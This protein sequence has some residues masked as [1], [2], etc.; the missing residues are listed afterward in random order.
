MELMKRPEDLDRVRKS[1]P[2][3]WGKKNEHAKDL[4]KFMQNGEENKFKVVFIGDNGQGDLVAAV[5]LL[6]NSEYADCIDFAYI[7]LVVDNPYISLQCLSEKYKMK[8]PL[9]AKDLY[10]FESYVELAFIMFYQELDSMPME[11]LKNIVE[12]YKKEIE[13]RRDQLNLTIKFKGILNHKTEAG[14]RLAEE[15]PELYEKY[16]R[17]NSWFISTDDAEEKLKLAAAKDQ[18]EF[19]DWIVGNQEK[20]FM[21]MEKLNE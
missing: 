9:T 21:I 6:Y 3:I 13:S 18:T 10:F 5:K 16:K 11:R 8:V 20:Y 17:T 12:L 7:R 14:I 15:A 2:L 4:S 1:K 19:K